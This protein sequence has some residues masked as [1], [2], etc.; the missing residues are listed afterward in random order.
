MIAAVFVLGILIGAG[1]AVVA[2]RRRAPARPADAEALRRAIAS[3]GDALA[4]THDRH[5]I[6]RVVLDTARLIARAEEARYWTVGGRRLQAVGTNQVL[7]PGSGLA[8][9]VA[10][11][12]AGAIGPSG[13]AEPPARTAMAVPLH[14]Q[15]R[16]AGVL[17]VYGRDERFTPD[18]LETLRTFARQAEAAIDNAYLHEEAARLA[19]TDGL[20]GVWNRRYFDLRAAEELE[21]AVRF[22]EPFSLVLLDLDDFKKVND[23]RGHQTGDAVLVELSRRLSSITREVDLVARY[24]GEEF[25]L[26]LPRTDAAGAR[27]LADKVCDAVRAEPFPADGEPL[28]LTVSGGVATYPDHGR[29]IKAL[30]AA[31]DAA[32]Y[33]AK[34]DGKNRV[35]GAV[36]PGSPEGSA[37][38]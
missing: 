37:S 5:A 12:D 28:C 3:L 2:V 20:T 26:V 6:L 13:D 9:K 36:E 7:A 22:G 15:G 18:E 10:E 19:I 11:R 34:A 31:A 16:L 17:A 14:L 35:E 25:A 1:V 4:S 24:G 21:A 38:T 8:G 23:T 33:R 27:L 30:V 32:L 29:S